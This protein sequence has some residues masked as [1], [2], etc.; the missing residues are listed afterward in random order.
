MKS[1][2]RK[3]QKGSE[4]LKF[5][6]M[7][8]LLLLTV[9]PVV[10]V[11]LIS[12][13]LFS[14]IVE[15]ELQ[16]QQL[17]IAT[18]NADDLNGLL[19]EKVASLESMVNSY[20]TEWLQGDPDTIVGYL[21]LMKAVSPDVTS[22]AYAPESGQLINESSV[23]FDISALDNFIRAK[24]E[25]T[26][27]ISDIIQDLGTKQNII[28][29]DIPILG[30][31]NEFR[32]IVQAV[33]SPGNILAEL[34]KNKMGE[35][36]TA[37]LLSKDGKYLAHASEQLVGKDLKEYVNEETAAVFE[38][39]VL[40]LDRGNTTYT[41]NAGVSKISSFAEVA[42][43]GWRV[44]VSGDEADLMSEVNHSERISYYI[45]LICA[46]VV[47]VI[48]MIASGYIL[49]PI[50]AITSLMKKVSAGTLSDRLSVKGKDE[51]H[52]LKHHI[53]LMLDSF[54]L[55]LRKLD[56]AV[57]H[58]A[59]SSEQ[60][61]AIAGSSVTASQHTS[62]AV[63]RITK[64]AQ[65][66]YES[67]EQSAQAMEE[68]SI[69]IQRIADSASIVNEHSQ[70][71]H[72]QV[73]YGDEVVQGAVIQITHVNE[74]VDR[75]AAMIQ[76]LEAKTAEINQ[77]VRYISE[78]A[79]QTNLLSLNASIEAAR[80]GEHGRGFAVVAG[81]VKKL[82]EQTTQATGT[83]AGILTEIQHSAAMTSASISE[84]I[85][86]VHKSV[87]QIGRVRE[88]FGTIVHAVVEVSNQINEVSAATQQLSASTE[89][90]SASMTQIVV[91]S[92]NSLQELTAVSG[93]TS[94]QHRSM[95]EISSSS[96]SLSHMAT[97][98]QE[99]VSR[100]QLD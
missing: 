97:E 36:S 16:D 92:Q 86:E 83:I 20:R 13:R 45:I 1:R 87:E 5:K 24:A 95:E 98:L 17:I 84:E 77:V 33:V 21:K 42:M 37:F 3:L 52:Q 51:I 62:L 25:K 14:G 61:T 69:G 73:T 96:E 91:I 41:D 4:S 30:S 67:S 85:R 23:T 15:K 79:N 99:M 60:L 89:E 19:E 7:V 70:Q 9:I 54:T 31:S 28:I 93:A 55:T 29:I 49:R 38:K 12:T 72:E 94:G 88:V 46:L 57:Q 39:E 32:G 48:S 68:M 75:T 22:F 66:Q 100:F 50:Y 53:N 90:V 18:V 56:E 44:V 82:S 71:V 64:G 6:F 26:V 47:A 63:E 40:T 2:L 8:F 43:T 80:A 10:L 81:E 35:S 78:I 65:E 74:A 59:A 27:G 58:T 76:E 11:A 34:N